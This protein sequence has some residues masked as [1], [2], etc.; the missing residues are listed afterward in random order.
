MKLYH[1]IGFRHNW[2]LH[3]FLKDEAGDGFIFSPVNISQ[4]DLKDKFS[5]LTKSCSFFDP[6]I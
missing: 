2:N 3:A 1:Q 6:Q 5:P 4:K